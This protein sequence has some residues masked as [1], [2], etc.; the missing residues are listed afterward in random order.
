MLNRCKFCGKK[1]IIVKKP[2]DNIF[3]F[4]C[5]SCNILIVEDN[6]GYKNIFEQIEHSFGYQ[7]NLKLRQ[8]DTYMKIYE[9]NL[10]DLANKIKEYKEKKNSLWILRNDGKRD[11]DYFM[12][13]F[14]RYLH[15]F[16]MSLYSL[17]EKSISLKKHINKRY[18][19]IVSKAE[20]SKK[21]Q[22][23][24][25]DEYATYLEKLRR[26][27]T[28]GIKNEGTAQVTFSYNLGMNET[29]ILINDKDLTIILY[30]YNIGV[31]KFYEWFSA[32]L[33]NVFSK[34]IEKTNNLIRK[35]K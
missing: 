31:K 9:H 18:G 35:I 7:I 6:N 26:D 25:I 13:E 20:Y 10:I 16:L 34:E 11:L 28:H 2:Q 3:T 14:M 8:L 32:K 22:E 4:F 5:Q 27:F 12:I 17:K 1:N 23:Y 21:L 29:Y 19:D 30:E 24:K 33:Y 15:N